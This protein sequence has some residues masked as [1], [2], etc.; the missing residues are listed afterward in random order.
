[1]TFDPKILPYTPNPGHA[2]VDRWHRETQAPG[3]APANS[4]AAPGN[5]PGHNGGQA[6]RK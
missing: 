6:D 5:A 2:D 3:A 4:P 1:M